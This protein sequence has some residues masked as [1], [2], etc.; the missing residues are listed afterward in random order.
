MV[1]WAPCWVYYLAEK[2]QKLEKLI[3]EMPKENAGVS[4][5]GSSASTL[6]GNRFKHLQ[7]TDTDAMQHQI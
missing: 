6:T 2:L 1:T 3:L 7:K 4:P 5:Q